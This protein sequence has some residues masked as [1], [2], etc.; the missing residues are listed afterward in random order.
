MNASVFAAA[1]AIS[2]AGDVS[3]NRLRHQS[4][5]QAAAEQDVQM[6]VFPELSLTGYER[7]LAEELAILPDDAILQPLRDLAHELRLTT[8]VGMPIRLLAGAPVMI[9][10]LI[11]GADGSLGSTA[12][13]T[14][15][16]AKRSPLRL[17]MAVRCCGWGRIASPGRCVPISATPAMPPQPRSGAPRCMRRVC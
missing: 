4:F 2:I 13:S 3:A 5:M 10:A 12:N 17:V 8:V 7:D 1:Q 11:L 15:T 16:L 9:G 6:L 14:C